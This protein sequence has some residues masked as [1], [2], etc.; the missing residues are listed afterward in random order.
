VKRRPSYAD[1]LATWVDEVDERIQTYRY[2]TD[3]EGYVNA[4]YFSGKHHVYWDPDTHEVVEPAVRSASEIRL[5]IPLATRIVMRLISRMLRVRRTPA[6]A[7]RSNETSSVMAARGAQRMLQHLWEWQRAN[8]L[9]REEVLPS[10]CLYGLGWYSVKWDPDAEAMRPERMTREPDQED[11]GLPADEE[12][13]NLVQLFPEEARQM[14]AEEEAGAPSALGE[15]VYRA[16]SYF[17][18]SVDP[19]AVRHDQLRYVIE[20]SWIPRDDVIRHYGRSVKDIE[21]TGADAGSTWQEK[22]ITGL[23]NATG[24]LTS[25]FTG[26]TAGMKGTDLVPGTGLRAE[27]VP[28]LVKK[29]WLAATDKYPAGRLVVVANGQ[30]LDLQDNPYGFVPFV[31]VPSIPIP[32]TSIRVPIMSLLRGLSLGIDRL[33]SQYMMNIRAMGNPAYCV[34]RSMDFDLDQIADGVGQIFQ[35]DP[36]PRDPTHKPYRFEAPYLGSF[37][38]EAVKI[39][40]EMM[41]ECAGMNEASRGENPSGGR[42][43]AVVEL[44][45]AKDEEGDLPMQQG[46]EDALSDLGTLTLRLARKFYREDRYA[47]I[48]GPAGEVLVHEVKASDFDHGYDVKVIGD[49]SLPRSWSDRVTMALQLVK[50][51]IINV[52]SEQERLGLLQFLEFAPLASLWDRGEDVERQRIHEEN[53]QM[54]SGAPVEVEAKDLHAMHAPDHRKFMRSDQFNRLLKSMPKPLAQRVAAVFYAHSDE[55]EN[56]LRVGNGLQP[57]DAEEAPS[58]AGAP[59]GPGAG[60]G[61]PPEGMG[62]PRAA[63]GS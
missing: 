47:R 12:E 6:V 60:R 63:L 38:A 15:V 23:T 5:S 9:S 28:I 24:M 26:A 57:L 42:S 27:D 51:Q 16:P 14:Q 50:A 52:A 32:G 44:L 22:L 17:D 62:T 39:L 36:D 35:Y 37:Y 11:E 49:A 40:R 58:A 59:T 13:Q 43:A 8:R 1:K 18:I 61:L 4:L 2:D 34:T 7:P 3:G 41:Y 53:L 29:M 55:H 54:L 46:F 56:W 33:V 21:A 30:L 45:S 31:P 20:R 19:F 25:L 10:A 48:V